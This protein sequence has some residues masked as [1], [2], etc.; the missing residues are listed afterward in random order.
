M[1]AVAFYNGNIIARFESPEAMIILNQMIA[2][3]LHEV[4][5]VKIKEGPVL[6]HEIGSKDYKK[7]ETEEVSAKKYT[8][9][10]RSGCGVKVRDTDHMFFF[11]PEGTEIYVK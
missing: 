10:E 9:K 8:F 4:K 2:G 7:I 3:Y 5:N 11:F 1:K 6:F